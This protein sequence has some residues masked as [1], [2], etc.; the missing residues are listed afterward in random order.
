MMTRVVQPSILQ[1]LL[2]KILLNISF[3][4]KQQTFLLC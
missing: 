2:F 1:P 3:H 4:K